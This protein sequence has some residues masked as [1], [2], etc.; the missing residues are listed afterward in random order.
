MTT[1][2]K[3]KTHNQGMVWKV[4]KLIKKLPDMKNSIMIEGLPGIGNVGKVAVDFMI[5]E[6]KAKKIM[7]LSSHSLPHTVF[8]KEDNLV[9]LP[10]IEIYHTKVNKGKKQ[11]DVLF[12]AGDIQPTNEVSSYEFSET[13][14]DLMKDMKCHEIITIGG[15]GLQ[16]EPKKPRLLC[17]GTS[18]KYIKD[19]VSGT[20]ISPKL[21]GV[22]GPIIGA[23]GLLIGLAKERKIEGICLLAETFAHPL[24]LGVKGSQEV[25]KVLEKKLELK[26]NLK[27]LSEEIQKVEKEIMKRTEQLSQM[28]KKGQQTETSYI[29]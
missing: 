6:L 12:L 18:K 22:V 21:Y 27:S 24:Y 15:I 10:T 7:E 3:R 29:G 11:R 20:K 17:T 5:E 26:L 25:L 16:D 4:R 13:V 9:E 1:F 23:T 8:V 14:L 19:F 28:M 2:K